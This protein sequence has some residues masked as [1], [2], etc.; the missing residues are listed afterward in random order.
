M[1]ETVIKNVL[2][3]VE[4]PNKIDTI[5]QILNK[6]TNGIKYTVAASK[7]HITRIDDSG[8]Y[9]MGID[10]DNNFTPDIVVDPGKKDVVKRLKELVKL[11]DFVIIATDPDREGEDIAYNLKTFLKIPDKKCAR[12]TF[13]EITEKAVSK[14]L[15]LD[16]VEQINMN[17]HNAALARKIL[18]KIIGFRLSPITMTKAGCRSAGRVQSAALKLLAIREDEIT[19]FVPTK[20]FELY[21]PFKYNKVVYRAQYKG[22]DKKKMVSIPD[23]ATVNKIILDCKD[24]DYILKSIDSKERKVAS[25]PP[26]TTSTFQQEVSSKLGYGSEK[27]MQCAQH[28]FEG[29]NIG[30]EHIALITYLRTDSTDLNA[31][32]AK[33]LAKYIKKNYGENYYAPPKQGKK[34]KNA[35]EGH[36]SLHVV[37]LEMTPSKLATYISD[38]QLL[39]VYK[40]IYDRTLACSMADCIMEDVEYSIYNGNHRFSY[41]THNIK[42]DGFKIIYNYD[43]DDEDTAKYPNIPLETKIN[44]MDLETV[45]KE[46]SPKSRYTEATLIKAMEDSGIGRPSTYT[47]TIKTL[48]DPDR[49]YTELEG[50]SFKVTEKGMR[51]SRY[52]DKQFGNIINLTYTSEMEDALDKIEKGELDYVAYLTEFYKDL[53]TYI[54]AAK[55]AEGMKAE[56]EQVGR[57]CPEC[58]KP[59]VYRVG[60]YGKFIACSGWAGKKGC[61]YTEKI[62]DPNKVVEKT[63]ETEKK[64]KP[65]DTGYKC[66]D[67]GK[68]ILKRNGKNGFWYSCGGFPKHKKVFSLEEFKKIVAK[69]TVNSSTNDLN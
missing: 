22:T 68:P 44:A 58:G 11:N 42:F 40:I 49:G 54:D 30:G 48:Q 1:A 21:L 46:T 66:P 51:L 43:E 64:E 3:I 69:Q 18:D 67:C 19:N 25:K 35:Q 57:N 27:S 65:E 31:D 59:L 5:T 9:N 45:A 17:M 12:G 20:Y 34:S 29:I 56:V 6:L 39:K 62:E 28:L 7:G 53:S 2:V 4:S 55:K 47:S 63:D 41:S 23:E 26:F 38:T 33:S 13:H 10:V 61:N 14:A 37:D 15:S 32:F 36:E 16:K 60:R 52:L 8:K 50:K 24:N